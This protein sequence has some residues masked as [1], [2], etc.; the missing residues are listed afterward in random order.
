MWVGTHAVITSDTTL[1]SPPRPH[2]YT[3]PDQ[4]LAI[5]T[6][7]ARSD[8]TAR[9]LPFLHHVRL[10]QQIRL[11]RRGQD[12]ARGLSQRSPGR[13]RARVPHCPSLDTVGLRQELKLRVVLGGSAANYAVDRAGSS[14]SRSTI[15]PFR[16]CSSQPAMGARARTTDPTS[17]APPESEPWAVATLGRG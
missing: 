13:R 2:I 7:L 16:V 12:L 4:P 1:A 3:N 9:L 5:H 8:S 11:R 6:L 15:I 10:L 14:R 17:F